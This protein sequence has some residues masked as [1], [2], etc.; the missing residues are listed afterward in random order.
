MVDDRRQIVSIL[1]YIGYESAGPGGRDEKFTR[2]DS[3]NVYVPRHR[4]ISTGFVHKI[5]KRAGM[6]TGTLQNGDYNSAVAWAK[7]QAKQAVA[8]Q[9]TSDESKK[10]AAALD[11]PGGHRI[12]VDVIAGGRK[13]PAIAIIEPDGSAATLVDKYTGQVIAQQ[14]DVNDVYGGNP[15]TIKDQAND[16]KPGM[17]G[18]SVPSPVSHLHASNLHSDTKTSGTPKIKIQPKPDILGAGTP[19]ITIHPKP[20]I[21]V[22]GQP[23]ITPHASNDIKISHNLN[24]PTK[25]D[26]RV[27]GGA[28]IDI[29]PKSDVLTS[30]QLKQKDGL[31]S[32]GDRILAAQP[33]AAAPVLPP[34]VITSMPAHVSGPIIIEV[35]SPA[36]VPPSPPVQ[37]FAAAADN[38]PTLPPQDNLSTPPPNLGILDL[39][40]SAHQVAHPGQAIAQ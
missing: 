13:I 11:Q 28:H 33:G 22:S 29:N 39:S 24:L 15:I 38:L 26:T 5:E 7:K 6:P 9:V 21:A 8:T 25:P 34:T 37:S 19:E 4:I 36:A 30:A 1:E 10:A 3:E 18:G 20:D 14:V 31:V 40:A 35:P 23:V 16:Q 32:A 12:P 27:S 17:L 2:A